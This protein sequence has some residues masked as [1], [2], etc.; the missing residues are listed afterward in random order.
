MREL[1]VNE[2]YELRELQGLE[3]LMLLKIVDAGKCPKLQWSQRVMKQLRQQLKG[4]VREDSF[5]GLIED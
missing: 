1:N 3:D 2:C 5:K 4:V